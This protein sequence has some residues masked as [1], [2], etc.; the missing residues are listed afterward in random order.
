MLLVLPKSD[1]LVNFICTELPNNWDFL[2]CFFLQHHFTQFS[3][4][5]N[6]L[7][8]KILVMNTLYCPLL[9]LRR[10]RLGTLTEVL[11]DN[12][13]QLFLYQDLA[14]H[15]LTH[16]FLSN[17]KPTIEITSLCSNLETCF[18]NGIRV[19]DNSEAVERIANLV[20]KV[21]FI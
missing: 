14:E 7:T 18:P 4:I 12:C 17:Y 3:H 15:S 9:L 5:F 2:F 20:N 19:Y 1:T 6:S 16:N 11:Y 13:F 10:Q 8:C 21:F